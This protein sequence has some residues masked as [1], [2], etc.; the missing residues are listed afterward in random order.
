MKT[1]RLIVLLLAFS[2]VF[3]LAACGG[4]GEGKVEGNGD[5]EMTLSIASEP[6]TIDPALNSAVDGAIMIQHMF[7]G[8]MTW[9]DDGEGNAVITE[10]QAESYEV[11]EDG[12]VYTFTLRDD[13]KWSDG[14]P[15][16]AQ[17]FVYAWQ[18][19]VT[20]ETAADYNYMIDM[21]VN[22][23][24]IMAGEVDPSELGIVAIDKSTLEITLHTPTPYFLEVCA[25]PATFPVRQDMIEAGGDQ[26]TF[27]EETYIGNGPYKMEQWEHNSFIRMIPN[28]NYYDYENL[29]PSSIK[30]MLMDDDN[31]K[32]AAYKG[33]EL[34]FIE[35]PPIDEI[36][37]LLASGELKVAD[38]IGTYYVCFN[39]QLA[40]FD[41]ARVREAFSLVIDRNYITEQMKIHHP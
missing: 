2:L 38:Y 36:P 21:V 40:P 15:V 26:W 24:E 11:S 17:D 39:N 9:E 16:T 6:Q 33:G 14:E 1:K 22:A 5:F 12:T 41:D 35:N 18:R 34:L 19:L 7:E 29:G 3:T 27:S 32:L 25:F 28:E 31:A 20:P 4:G 30:F 8:L 13:A 23:N 10:G 37:A